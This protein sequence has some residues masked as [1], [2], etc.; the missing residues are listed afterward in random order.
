MTTRVREIRI[1]E[2]MCATALDPQVTHRFDTLAKRE[3]KAASWDEGPIL[4]LHKPQSFFLTK[5][6]VATTKCKGSIAAQV[7]STRLGIF[8]S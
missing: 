7:A 6:D 4:R 3:P 5:H 2:F 8:G 1:V